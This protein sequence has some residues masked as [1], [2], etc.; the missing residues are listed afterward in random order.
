MTVLLSAAVS[1]SENGCNVFQTASDHHRGKRSSDRLLEP[2]RDGLTRLQQADEATAGPKDLETRGI[3]RSTQPVA[4]A[5]ESM[6]TAMGLQ[7]A[8]GHDPYSLIPVNRSNTVVACG[9]V[10]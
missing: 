9:S 8:M 10:R 2:E 5:C 3:G 4:V 7:I 1:R 6:P